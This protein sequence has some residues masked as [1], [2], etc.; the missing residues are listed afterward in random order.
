M[1]TAAK[2]RN[3]VSNNRIQRSRAIE[4]LMVISRLHARPADAER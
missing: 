3:A 4:P 2:P 1:L